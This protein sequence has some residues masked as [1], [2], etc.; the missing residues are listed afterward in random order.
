MEEHFEH[1][2]THEHSHEHEHEEAHAHTHKHDNHAHE[3]HHEHIDDKEKLVKLLG[4]L[5]DHNEHHAHEILHLAEDASNLG[6]AEA[7]ALL[8]EA[9]KILDKS[10]ALLSEAFGKL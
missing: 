4:Y 10:N 1:E 2:H 5:K 8:K 7:A 9:S 6:N 3:H